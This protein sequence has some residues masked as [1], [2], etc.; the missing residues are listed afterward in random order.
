MFFTTTKYSFFQKKLLYYVYGMSI[1][2]SFFC[3]IQIDFF[4]FPLNNQNGG[5]NHDGDENIFYFSHNSRH[6]DFVPWQ[7]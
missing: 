5:L 7:H 2:L 3:M 6:F 4:N 1:G